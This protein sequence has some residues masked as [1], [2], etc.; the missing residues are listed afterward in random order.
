MTLTPS[1]KYTA[2]V[3]GATP[4][5]GGLSF[6]GTF[7]A[8]KLSADAAV[9]YFNTNTDPGIT[10]LVE[11]TYTHDKF[12]LAT[13][14]FLNEKG[15]GAKVAPNYPSQTIP[16]AVLDRMIIYVEPGYALSD[17]VAI[18]LPLEYHDAPA[19]NAVAL[20]Y[21]RSLWVVPTLY[22]YPGSNIQWWIWGQVIKPISGLAGTD[23]LFFAGS[24]L[25]FNF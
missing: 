25:I 15:D 13:S 9:N 1:A 17:R 16:G 23:P 14:L 22:I 19:N 5:V 21:D 11:P 8:V 2:G 6:D 24:E 10:V 4:F 3:P 12:S 18:G 20:G 7:G